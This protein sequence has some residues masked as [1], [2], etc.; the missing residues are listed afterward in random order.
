MT[1]LQYKEFLYAFA[2]KI[3]DHY[4]CHNENSPNW[5]CANSEAEK[6]DHRRLPPCGIRNYSQDNRSM[7]SLKRI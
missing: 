2:S 5:L 4:S 7:E 1:G 3:T 6:P